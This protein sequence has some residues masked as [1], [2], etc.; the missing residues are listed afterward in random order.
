MIEKITS[1]HQ[2]TMKSNSYSLIEPND[3]YS[4]Q[5]ILINNKEKSF[6][7]QF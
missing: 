5:R 1:F 7:E 2:A 4:G 6:E 3:S